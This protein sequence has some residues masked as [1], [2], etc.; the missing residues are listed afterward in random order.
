M[1]TFSDLIRNVQSECN[2]FSMGV[3]FYLLQLISEIIIFS[4]ICIFLIY[5]NFQISLIVISLFTFIELI[6]Q[7]KPQNLRYWGDKRHVHFTSFK[8]IQQSLKSFRE[9]V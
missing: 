3:V 6:F 1:R 5:Y 8:Q 7:E 9:L 4:F 2:I